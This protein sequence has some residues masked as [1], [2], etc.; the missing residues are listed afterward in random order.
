MSS[1]WPSV[2][3]LPL[4]RS[5]SRPAT[6]GAPGMGGH[7]SSGSTLPSPNASRLGR[8]RPPTARATLP[9]VSEPSSPKSA[10][11]GKAPAPTASS[12][13]THARGMRLFYGGRGK[14]SGTARP[15]RLH[16]VRDL[17][18]GGGDVGRG[19]DLPRACGEGREREVVAKLTQETAGG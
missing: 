19:E 2:V 11:S 7:P 8:S 5:R 1:Q 4:E 14:R 9:S 10:A 17:A 18:R 3:S 13:M 16:S 15:R 6:A 12:T